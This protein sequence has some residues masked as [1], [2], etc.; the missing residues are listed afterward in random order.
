M[1]SVTYGPGSLVY[2]RGRDWIV[3]TGSDAQTLRVRPVSG[4]EDDQTLI[5]LALEPE[6]VREARFPPPQP[7]PF[8]SHDSALLL[9]D[10]LLLSLRRGAGPFRGFAQI[11]VEPRAYQL[12]PLMMALK[13][14]PV[15]LLIADDVGVGKTIEAALIA[16]ELLDR[17]DIHRTTVLCPPH[18]VDQWLTELEQRFHLHPVAVTAT[19]AA[20]LERHLPQSESIFSAHPHTVVSLDYIKNERRRSTFLQSCP[21]FV[22]IDEAHTCAATGQGRH[23]RHELLR[24]LADSPT[25]HMVLLTATPHSGDEGAF[26]RLLGLLDRDFERLSEATGEERNRL[27]DRLSRHFVQRRRKDIP[28]WEENTLFPRRESM[29]L[30]YKLTGAW[31]TFFDAVLDYCAAVVESAEGD[32]RRQ[33]LNFWGTLA[34]MRCVASSPAAAV[35][36]LRTRA[37]LS[38]EDEADTL[39]E[40]VLDGAA[41]A[42]PDD[43]VEPPASTDDADLDRLITQA[44]RLTGQEGDPKLQLLV[45]HLEHLLADGF[46]PVVFCRFIATAH[47]LGR[48]LK[49]RFKDIEVDVI[50]GELTS[51]ER[52]EK[53]ELLGGVER[54]LLIA[55]DCLSEGINLQKSFT[56]VVHYDLSW[57]PTRHEQREGRVDRF[58]QRAPIVR[59]TLLYGADNPVDGAVLEVILRKAAKIREELGVPVPLPDDG[60]ALTQV[61][62][63]AVLLKHRGGGATTGMRQLALFDAG[64]K[65]VEEKARRTVFAQ[66]RLKP[67]DVLPE[68]HKTLA[69]VG[70]Q[71]DVQRFTERALARLGSSLERLPQGFRAS[72][73][74]LPDEVRERM[75][76]EGLTG[77][78]RIDFG[79]PPAPRCQP[80]HRSHPLVSVLAETLLERTLASRQEE[81]AATT[82]SVLGRVGC[83]T[84]SG[85]SHVTTVALL[86]LRHQLMSTK[87]G[88]PTTLLVEEATAVAWSGAPDSVLLE[89]EDALP[90]LLHPPIIEPKDHV[91][92]RAIT[93]AL[94]QLATRHGELEAFAT[95]RA[96]ALLADHRRVREAADA[97]GSYS[98]KALLPPDVIGLFV[99]LPSLD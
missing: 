77:A 68:L 35:Q 75:A 1:T 69:A 26:F 10:A 71:E 39:Q 41:D 86:R 87:A 92:D 45:E 30:T 84:A 64:W 14:D 70:A 95:R 99:I 78:P 28:E 34:L 2:A 6:P 37:G 7:R 81:T 52:E 98:V 9:R 79:Q 13:L 72:L 36:A 51:Q 82:P 50:T 15:R 29:E 67:K 59:A 23:Q 85:I 57:N 16:R 91:K 54:S 47:Y 42:L 83:W 53:V 65:T 43:D 97:R 5:H 88:R 94:A 63:K 55:T 89:A 90:L 20:R 27:R 74:P 61:L 40:R 8:A 25:R 73:T 4:S 12:V 76:V 31:Q 44:E 19:S 38:G 96:E 17:G 66:H 60:H 3:L 49:G 62:L 56:A 32:A 21:D 33:R 93:Q 22:I 80:V 24:A 46:N 11:A 48:H 58:G 18:L